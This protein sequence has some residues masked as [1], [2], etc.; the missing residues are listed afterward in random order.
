MKPCGPRTGTVP[1]SRLLSALICGTL[2]FGCA[3]TDKRFGDDEWY[4]STRRVSAKAVDLTKSTASASYKRMQKYLKEK[5]VLQTFHDAGEHSED[6][7]LDVL[8]KAGVGKRA[9]PTAKAGGSP[10]AK[11]NGSTPTT[12]AT[13]PPV[14]KEGTKTPPA[15]PPKTTPGSPS[16]TV[17]P[18]PSNTTPVPGSVQMPE[19][20]AGDYRWPLD[21]GIISSEYG[22]R[23]GKMHKGIDIAADTGENVFAVAPGQVIYAGSGLRGYGNV[24][25]LR[26]DRKVTSLY[27]HNSEIKVKQGDEVK[28]GDLIALLGSTGHSTGPHVHFEFRDGD[29]AVNPHTLL[30]QSKIPDAVATHAW[31][32][33]LAPHEVTALSARVSL[34]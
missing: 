24:V 14:S 7:V 26:H 18:P 16:K 20:Y 1:L 6:A 34:R 21:A 13:K 31:V 23:W 9:P 22:E 28:Q 11:S 15:P 33:E 12:G 3:A 5:D 17:P 10:P 32:P 4:Q 27:A 2:L 8:H 25:I 19:R 30:P 29:L